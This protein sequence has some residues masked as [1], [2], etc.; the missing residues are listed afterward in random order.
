[1]KIKSIILFYVF[2]LMVLSQTPWTKSVVFLAIPLLIVLIF[3]HSKISSF[4]F[5][6]ILF[7]NLIVLL[8]FIS[9]IVHI[10]EY[11]MYY[12]ARDIMYFI[13]API[14]ITIGIYLY[15]ELKDFD[16]LLKTIVLTSLLITVYR[17]S[18]FLINPSLI[19]QLGLE[20]RSKYDLSNGTAL[21][22]FIIVFYA[23]KLHYK[24]FNKYGELTIMGLSFFSIAISFSRTFY[25]LFILALI[26]PYIN[27][28]KIIFKMYGVAV[29][30]VVFIIFG[31]HFFQMDVGGTQG[32]NFQ[33]KVIHSID[34]ITVKDYDDALEILH[35]WRGY[36]AFLGR[37][38]Y[39]EG[40]LYE[41]FFGQGYGCVVITP[42]WIFKGEDIMG[43]LPMFHNGYITILLKAGLVGFLFFFLFLYTLLKTGTQSLKAA[44][45][46]EQALASILLQASVF[47]ILFQTFVIHGIFTTTV[48][49]MLLILIGIILQ[50]L[51]IYK[52][53]TVSILNKSM[54]KK[55]NEKY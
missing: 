35:N 44:M 49:V 43:V 33:T 14:F 18:E 39:Y 7:I 1:M 4:G 23:R 32:E 50:L 47:F 41:I 55:L 21:L 2:L 16:L 13:Q 53:R 31:N 19:F 6:K 48:P 8:G 5:K 20:T 12:F 30:L 34:E 28:K 3:R 51:S 46:N 22:A 40:N 15:N 27:K 10:A 9:G 24:L 37:S 52:S 25:V 36:E 26:I 54:E 11:N 29:V 17:F 38:K 42:E 45:S